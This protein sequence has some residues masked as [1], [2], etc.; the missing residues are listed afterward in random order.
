M[1][2][3]SNNQYLLLRV[4]IFTMKRLQLFAYNKTFIT[5][6]G[7]IVDD[8]EEKFE[9]NAWMI[10]TFNIIQF[11]IMFAKAFF[12]DANFYWH[13][14]ISLQTICHDNVVNLLPLDCKYWP[15]FSLWTVY[16]DDDH[17]ERMIDD[18]DDHWWG[19]LQVN[20]EKKNFSLSLLC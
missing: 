6:I 16:Y 19:C 1:F 18:D 12:V 10:K 2:S 4:I 11:C 7:L 20:E 15:L 14:K 17:E 13:K 8:G 9:L 3:S 5:T